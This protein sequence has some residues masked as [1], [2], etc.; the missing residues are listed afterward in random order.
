[1]IEKPEIPAMVPPKSQ[2]DIPDSLQ[3][4]QPKKAQDDWNIGS[5]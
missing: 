3:I 4:N 5:T 2:D 1:M